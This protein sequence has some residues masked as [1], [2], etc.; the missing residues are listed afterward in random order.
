[1]MNLMAFTSRTAKQ[2]WLREK[3]LVPPSS[4]E[5]LYLYKNGYKQIKLSTE[6]RDDQGR[7]LRSFWERM[8]FRAINRDPDGNV[9]MIMELTPKS[10]QYQYEHYIMSK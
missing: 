6:E 8:G 1:M 4:P 9:D 5:I 3:E 7:T 2:L 10:A